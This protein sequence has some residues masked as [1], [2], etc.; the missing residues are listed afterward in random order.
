MVLR[1]VADHHP[2]RRAG[3]PGQRF[4]AAEGTS[5]RR[6]DRKKAVEV[7]ALLNEL[8]RLGKDRLL[9]DVAAGKSYLGLLAVELLGFSRLVVIER[10][11]CANRGL[12]RSPPRA[13]TAARRSTSAPA[14]PAI[15]RSGLAT[16]D[17]VTALHACGDASD[18]VLDAAIRA[19]A[20]WIFLV[21][22]CYAAAVP[23]A[24]AAEAHA[25][26][27]GLPRHAAVRRRFVISLIDAERTLRLEAAGW[28]TTIVPFVAET[29]TPHNLLFRARRVREPRRMREAGER[30]ACDCVEAPRRTRGVDRVSLRARSR[31]EFPYADQV[32]RGAAL[33][34]FP[35][36][37]AG[38]RTGRA[39]RSR[40]SFLRAKPMDE[41]AL[42]QKPRPRKVRALARAH[43][44]R[45]AV[46]D[47]E[48]LA[49]VTTA[50]LGARTPGDVAAVLASQAARAAPAGSHARAL[51]E[52]SGAAALERVLADEARQAAWARAQ[53]N[54]SRYQLVERAAS[55][56]SG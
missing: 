15:P 49:S 42:R 46:D 41:R 10:D 56:E 3:A 44:R 51:I 40:S 20:R 35:G 12:P 33:P 37:M 38:R 22:C 17:V 2:R 39:R 25:D 50:L 5:L 36:I 47:L 43:L 54:E 1:R 52:S 45:R 13:S 27:L 9:V 24:A 55:G 31:A 30:L 28:E 32:L 6:E 23:F 26:R 53:E 14:T 4:I 48:R 34:S 19:E 18:R 8:A 21:P 7:T 29:V 11:L 16:P